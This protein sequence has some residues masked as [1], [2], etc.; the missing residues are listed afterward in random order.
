MGITRR[1][2]GT[3]VESVGRRHQRCRPVED[4]AR[5]VCFDQGGKAL[6]A[7]HPE[8]A[9]KLLDRGRQRKG[10]RDRPEHRQ[11]EPGAKLR[12]GANPRWIVVGGTRDQSR[13]ETPED[14]E[15]A[16]PPASGVD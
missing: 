2:D 14:G 16:P 12:V 3:D 11:S 1:S 9:G 4:R 7:R 6:L 8:P 5:E 15:A 10:N 13:S